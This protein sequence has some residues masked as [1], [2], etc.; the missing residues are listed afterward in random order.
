MNSGA[1][2]SVANRT[3]KVLLAWAW[4]WYALKLGA[5]VIVLLRYTVL[6]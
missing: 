3:D 2:T 1:K 5:L 4:G 6:A